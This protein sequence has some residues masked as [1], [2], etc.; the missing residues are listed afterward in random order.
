MP[1]RASGPV[2]LVMGD[3]DLVRPLALAGIRCALFA[4]PDEPARHSRRVSEVLP[5]IDHWEEQERLAGALAAWG[6][7]QESPPVAFPQTDGDLLT[8]SRHRERLLGPLRFLLADHDL[9][10]TLLDKEAF[11]ELARRLGLQVP[12]SVRIVAGE[13]PPAALA[14]L[15]LPLV[16]KPVTRHRDRWAPVGEHAK[17]VHAEDEAALDRLVGQLRRHGIDAI[18]QEAVPGPESAI[19]SHHAYVD[20]SGRLVADFTGRKIRTRP[21][22]YGHSCALEITDDASV[23]EAGRAILA[24]LGLSGFA[25]LDFKR[26]P[27]GA[28]RLLEINPRA[29]LW[30]HP[31]ALAGVN[32]AALAYA[33]LTGG[34]RPPVGPVRAGVRWCNPWL[35][36]RAARAAGVPLTSW[37]RFLAGC[38]ARSALAASDP[39]PFAR[40]LVLEAV[41]SRARR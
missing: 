7:R 39:M 13:Q 2:A 4:A 36:V 40:G 18:V 20:A 23:R 12:R 19:E 27:D 9:V 25:K 30:F 37:L 6:A 1:A 24:E 8:L 16:V 11:G 38:E 17:A 31:A 5:W 34:P 28:L 15:A 3:G 21:A 26:A 32:L 41:A 35:D 29:T 33:D 14:E 10:A 22:R